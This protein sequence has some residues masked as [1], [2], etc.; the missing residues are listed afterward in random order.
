MK[1][2]ITTTCTTKQKN[3]N[4]PHITMSS[5]QVNLLEYSRELQNTPESTCSAC[6]IDDYFMKIKVIMMCENNNTNRF[7]KKSE[8]S[9]SKTTHPPP[10]IRVE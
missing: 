2:T 10:H 3:D 1:I 8:Y 7:D 5:P 6:M 9:L 4:N